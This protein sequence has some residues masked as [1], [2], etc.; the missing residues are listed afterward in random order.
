MRAVFER[1]VK[2][3]SQPSENVTIPPD[4]LPSSLIERDAVNQFVEMCHARHVCRTRLG[5]VVQEIK[6]LQSET[7]DFFQNAAQLCLEKSHLASYLGLPDTL[8][9]LLFFASSLD[10]RVV[11]QISVRARPP[12]QG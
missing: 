7:A 5:R 2:S 1:I 6:G 9:S 4:M 12:R 10:T 11:L 3:R 8:R